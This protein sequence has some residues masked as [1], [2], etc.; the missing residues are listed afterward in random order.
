MSDDQVKQ[1]RERLANYMAKQGRRNTRQ[2]D[3]IVDVFFREGASRHLSLQELL[4][5]VQ[6]V[7]PGVGYATVYRTMKLLTDAEVAL[8]RRFDEG[9]ARYE[10]AENGE[11]HD[12]LICTLCGQIL[13]FED[14]LI[15]RRQRE[16]AVQFGLRIVDHRHEI[17]G[18]CLDG[19]ACAARAAERD[20]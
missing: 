3:V 20:A 1:A 15:E 5:L 9:N 8:E 4:D 7:E 10:L 2:R 12:H 6:G 18:E 19:E 17:Y 11:H 16:I 13:E 14:P